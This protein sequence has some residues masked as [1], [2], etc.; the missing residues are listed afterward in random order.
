MNEK[1]ADGTFNILHPE[2]TVEQVIIPSTGG[3][4]AEHFID[5]VKKHIEI[6]D[7]IPSNLAGKGVFFEKQGGV[8]NTPNKPT[9]QDLNDKLKNIGHID[10]ENL[11]TAISNTPN[12]GKLILNNGATYIISSSITINKDI[13][14]DGNNARIVTTGTD[15]CLSFEE[16]AEISNTTFE[17]ISLSLEGV[18]KSYKITNNKFIN[19]QGNV[20]ECWSNLKS[21]IVTD[22]ESNGTILNAESWRNFN[23]SGGFIYLSFGDGDVQGKIDFVRIQ[24]NKI[25]NCRGG[26]VIFLGGHYL[27]LEVTDN[28]IDTMA[29]RAIGFWATEYAKGIVARNRIFKCGVLKEY[30][31]NKKGSDGNDAGVGCNA[32]YSAYGDTKEVEVLDNYIEHVYE[33]GIEGEY[34]CI[35]RNTVKNTGMDLVNH[36]TPSYEGIF[37]MGHDVIIE[38]N[39]IINPKGHGIYKYEDDDGAYNFLIRRN[40]IICEEFNEDHAGIAFR[41]ANGSIYENIYIEDNYIKNFATA[42]EMPDNKT[43]TNV[44]IG[45]NIALDYNLI[46][47]EFVGA[48]VDFEQSGVPRINLIKNGNFNQWETANN[49]FTDWTTSN[50]SL[51]LV[52]DTYKNSAKITATDTFNG[53]IMQSSFGIANPSEDQNR[54]TQ[55]VVRIKGN[56]D[57]LVRLYPLTATGAARQDAWV[58]QLQATGLSAT[59]FKTIKI[60]LP[61]ESNFRLELCNYRN[62]IGSWIEVSEAA[63]YLID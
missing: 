14:I 50:A 25:Y 10:S 61:Y 28:F 20:V 11:V 58:T 33:N 1:N 21:L 35:K 38:D 52:T 37:I 42:I 57:L 48:G 45:K 46:I 12:G 18:N 30:D 53:R 51:Q 13:T 39:T 43:Y 16:N 2:T 62:V 29:Q 19:T 36:P 26:T 22:N 40:T 44:K 17:K 54:F 23:N 41:T 3:N 9:I 47:S 32:I 31:E 8:S 24:R 6:V 60:R 49:K 55:L 59:D 4:I 7:E 27:D 56:N 63:M 15:I 5:A 34:K